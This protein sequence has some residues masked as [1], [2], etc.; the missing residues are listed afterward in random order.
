MRLTETELYL[1]NNGVNCYAYRTLGCHAVNAGEQ[2][3]FYRFSVYAPNAKRVS[4]VGDF[5]GW[6]TASLRMT[7]CGSTGVWEA[8]SDTSL[9]YTLYIIGGWTVSPS[10]G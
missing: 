7:P 9:L 3:K 1:F 6:D 10:R 2:A 4:V 5:N 8:F